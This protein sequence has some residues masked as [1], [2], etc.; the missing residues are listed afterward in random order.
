MT[1]V[2]DVYFYNKQSTII[3]LKSIVFQFSLKIKDW[4]LVDVN[5]KIW[6]KLYVGYV[7]YNKNHAKEFLL[8]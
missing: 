8:V 3:Y 1:F 6:I 2:V 5:L 4:V 7:F